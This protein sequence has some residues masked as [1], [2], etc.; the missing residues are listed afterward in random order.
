MPGSEKDK[1]CINKSEDDKLPDNKLNEE[2]ISN[3]VLSKEIPAVNSEP[4]KT[5]LAEKTETLQKAEK[6][7]KT[8]FKALLTTGEDNNIDYIKSKIYNFNIVCNEPEKTKVR[9]LVSFDDRATWKKWDGKTWTEVN[10]ASG[11]ENI[12]FSENGNTSA[13][14]IKGLTDYTLQPGEISLDFAVEL[15]ST[16]ELISPSVNKAEVKYY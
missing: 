16:D 3:K 15:L 13:E 5:A 6:L 1:I 10:T 11:I 14:V 12:N 2:T 7:E 4:A 9:W 8:V